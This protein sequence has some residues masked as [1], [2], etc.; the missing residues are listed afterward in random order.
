MIQ[1][2]AL[3]KLYIVLLTIGLTVTN[4]T[5]SNQH[6]KLLEVM[7]LLQQEIEMVS[8]E[9]EQLRDLLKKQHRIDCDL[10]GLVKSK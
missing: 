8:K 5:N 1:T 7:K 10:I 6:R 4:V 3:I 2:N 9:N